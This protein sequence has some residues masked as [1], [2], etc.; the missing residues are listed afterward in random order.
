MTSA[1]GVRLH[2][3]ACAKRASECETHADTVW[4]GHLWT[5]THQSKMG[6]LRLGGS[7]TKGQRLRNHGWYAAARCVLAAAGWIPRE[8]L[9]FF[10]R[11]LGF[12]AYGVLSDDRLRAEA[13]LRDAFGNP[14]PLS[15]LDVFLGLGEDVADMVRLLDA[16]EEPGA[17]LQLHEAVEPMV[18]EAMAAG[19]G[20]VFAT[21]HLGPME[22]MAALVAERGL[23]VVTVARESYD[24]RFTALFETERMRRG[25]QTIFRGRP[26]A[27]AAIV[28]ALRRGSIVGFPMDW[29]GRGMACMQTEFL[30]RRVPMPLGPARIALRTGASVLVGTPERTS[31]GAMRVTVERFGG[32]IVR[33]P[34]CRP[35]EVLTERLVRSLDLRIRALPDRWPWMVRP[36]QA[37]IPTPPRFD[38]L[39]RPTTDR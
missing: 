30:G 20:V 2:S 12:A 15:V 19:R 14:A 9:P 13:R 29:A 11:A 38:R 3:S 8:R 5:Q 32:E 28:R 4:A 24:P 37:A 26:G 18:R 7:W 17:T 25:V 1:K 10:G 16:H 33:S 31:G 22:R 23:P 27:A 39:Q 34:T 6:D 21:A 35:D 36:S